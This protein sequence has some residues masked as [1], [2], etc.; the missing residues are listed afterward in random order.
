MDEQ[1]I[2]PIINLV[3][4]DTRL[5]FLEAGAQKDLSKQ[6]PG[7]APPAASRQNNPG[8]LPDAA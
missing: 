3:L 2:V 7:E 4:G 6:A 1:F 5:L 8:S